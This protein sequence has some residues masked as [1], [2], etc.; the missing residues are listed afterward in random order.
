MAGAANEL[1][2]ISKAL[3]SL[4]RKWAEDGAKTVRKA[5]SKTLSADTGGDASLSGAPGKLKV[6][7]RVRGD[8]IVTL[9]VTPG[10]R[11]GGAGRWA[12]LEHGT[13]PHT[14][15]GMFQGAAHPG[16]RPKRTWSR[17]MDPATKALIDDARKKFGV[18]VKGYG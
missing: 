8:A 2:R 14:A 11:R 6:D 13:L 7:T 1:R 15:G 5:G 17:A 12:W 4:P 18:A 10:P 9:T 16:T 3:R